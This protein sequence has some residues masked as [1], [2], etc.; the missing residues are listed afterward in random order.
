MM[1]LTAPDQLAA[2]V[3]HLGLINASIE[4]IEAKVA[5]LKVVR[6][7]TLQQ[8]AAAAKREA[9]SW[10]SVDLLALYDSLNCPGLHT[11]WTSAGLPHVQRMRA[12]VADALR[13]APN[14]P[15]SGGWVGE[16]NWDGFE[17]PIPGPF[18]ANWTPV[19]YVLYAADAEP[20]YCGSTEHFLTRIKTHHRD[21]KP[22]VAWRAAPCADREQAFVL[23][24]RLL[25]QSCP[26]MNKRAGR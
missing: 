21:G 20:I 12:D 25:K 4:A 1:T 8:I 15:A 11:A 23:E 6:A 22:F 7:E 18:P 5:R 9:G 3:Q 10:S 2:S 19:V 16:W 13:A 24:D 14:D 17:F 26:P